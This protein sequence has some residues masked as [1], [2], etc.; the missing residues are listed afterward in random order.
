MPGV[1]WQAHSFY[2]ASTGGVFHLNVT[3]PLE[4][5]VAQTA[6]HAYYASVSWMDHQIGRILDELDALKLTD[7]TIVLLHGD[8]GWQLGKRCDHLFSLFFCGKS[9]TGCG[10]SSFT[11][12]RGDGSSPRR[13]LEASQRLLAHSDVFN[14]YLRVKIPMTFCM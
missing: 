3:T 4:D 14:L 2:N 1:A 7:N 10:A 12:V 13:P 6:R 5:R 9:R 8:H 11:V